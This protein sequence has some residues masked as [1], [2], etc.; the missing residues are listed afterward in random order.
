MIEERR[1][2]R[3]GMYEARDALAKTQDPGE[4]AFLEKHIEGLREILSVPL[5]VD[6]ES[7]APFCD[8]SSPLHSDDGAVSPR[9]P[10]EAAQ[11]MPGFSPQPHMRSPLVYV[12]NRAYEGP[13]SISISESE[14]QL[15]PDAAAIEEMEEVFV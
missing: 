13:S 5:P 1:L 7:I 4:R 3:E 12:R 10:L 6:D 15:S 2:L 9:S 14:D 8:A 11:G